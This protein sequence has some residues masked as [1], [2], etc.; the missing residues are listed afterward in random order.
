MSSED[1]YAILGVS[2]DAT[3]AEI[4]KAYKKLALKYHPD[5]VKGGEQKQAVAAEQF[6]KIS[7]AAETLLDPEMKRAYDCEGG[8]GSGDFA[9]DPSSFQRGFG[10]R[11]SRGSRQQQHHHHRSRPFSHDDAFSMFEAFFRDFEDMHAGMG[12]G[13]A[14][15]SNRR[16][17]GG[18]GAHHRQQQQGAFE[19]A[20]PFNDP[21]FGSMGMGMGMG[22]LGGR[23]DPFS[24]MESMMRSSMQH[25]GGAS[26]SSSSSMSFSSSSMGG[27]GGISKRT[28]TKTVTVNGKRKT[29]TETVTVGPDGKEHV[30][31][32]EYEDDASHRISMGGGGGGGHASSNRSVSRRTAPRG[33][34]PFAD[35]F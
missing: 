14:K 35:F 7:E 2:R 29:V 21:F 1:F 23:N 4:K 6:K 22:M 31:R 11:Q 18:G 24:R 26:S 19:D 27:G 30:D 34:D 13:G 15:T 8:Q 10:A 25:G 9:D 12:V 16:Q 3:T 33:R 28:S 17:G 32:Q 5:R 20:D